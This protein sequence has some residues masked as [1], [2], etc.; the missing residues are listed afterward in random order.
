[1]CRAVEFSVLV[2]FVSEELESKQ[3]PCLQTTESFLRLSARKL[4]VQWSKFDVQ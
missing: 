1:M 4:I 2:Y 3:E